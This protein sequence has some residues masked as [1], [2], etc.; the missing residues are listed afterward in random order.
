MK[1]SFKKS[2]AIAGVLAAVLAGSA[3]AAEEQVKPVGSDIS[4]QQDVK[5][6]TEAQKANAKYDQHHGYTNINKDAK[7]DMKEVKKDSRHEMKEIKK[8]AKHEAKTANQAWKKDV[9]TQEEARKENNSYDKS[10]GYPNIQKPAEA[11]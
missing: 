11:K 9:K 7:H 5:N 6:Q 3:F 8:D 1:N 2:L 4:W 10:H